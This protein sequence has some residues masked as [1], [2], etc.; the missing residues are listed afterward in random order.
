[1]THESF[2]LCFTF[3]HNITISTLVCNLHVFTR[4][5]N[6]QLTVNSRMIKCDDDTFIIGNLTFVT[7]DHAHVLH[8]KKER[9]NLYRML[10]T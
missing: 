2:F 8:D 10:Y 1:M 7:Y 6:T 9:T 5:D 3:S 4:T